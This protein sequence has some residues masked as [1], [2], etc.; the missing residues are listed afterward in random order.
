MGLLV[1]VFPVDPAYTDSL[2]VIEQDGVGFTVNFLFRL[3]L[4]TLQVS[5]PVLLNDIVTS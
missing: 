2:P 3:S 4:V 5:G 1:Y